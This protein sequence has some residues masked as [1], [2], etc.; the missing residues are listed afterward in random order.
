M[1]VF[2]RLLAYVIIAALW[3]WFA[4]SLTAKLGYRGLSRKLWFVSLCIPFLLGFTLVAILA[5]P[6][7]V[8][9]ELLQLR[10]ESQKLAKQN[11]IERELKRLKRPE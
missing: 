6:W 1:D 11:D 9:K 10:A 4:W 3:V 2:A 7:P 8:Y 5:L